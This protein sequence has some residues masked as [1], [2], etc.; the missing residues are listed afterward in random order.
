M[1]FRH[2][3]HIPGFRQI[4]RRRQDFAYAFRPRGA[5]ADENGYIGPQ[6]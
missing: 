3:D 1:A 4:L 6:G 5:T 2:D